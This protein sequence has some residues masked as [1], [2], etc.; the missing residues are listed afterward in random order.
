MLKCSQI[1]VCGISSA[2]L[3]RT[4][5]AY[6]EFPNEISTANSLDSADIS[7]F[8]VRVWQWHEVYNGKLK[9]FAILGEAFCCKTNKMETM[10]AAEKL[11]IVLRQ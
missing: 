7:Q 10:T 5:E 8:K 9:Q 4:D 1:V 3:A 6:R 11:Q 2:K